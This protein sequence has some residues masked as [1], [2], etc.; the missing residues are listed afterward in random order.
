MRKLKISLDDGNKYT[1][2]T[3]SFTENKALAKAMK[4][5]KTLSRVKSLQDQFDR[6]GLS[7]EETNEMNALLMEHEEEYADELIRIARLSLGKIHKEF[8]FVEDKEQDAKVAEE[9]GNIIDL[10]TLKIVFTF[11]TT[12]TISKEEGVVE[13]VSFND[14]DLTNEK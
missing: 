13:T 12:G 6:T 2:C 7:V 8:A 9:F 10:R 14:I 11:A 4:S 5:N 1:F 3:L